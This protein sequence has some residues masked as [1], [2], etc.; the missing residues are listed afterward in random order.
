MIVDASL[1]RE[2]SRRPAGTDQY[3]L[4]IFLCAAAN[5]RGNTFLYC[6]HDIG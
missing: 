6:W 2:L 4:F 3:F 1:G 5:L